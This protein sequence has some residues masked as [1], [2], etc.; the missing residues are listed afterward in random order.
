MSIFHQGTNHWKGLIVNERIRAEKGEI[1]F[2]WSANYFSKLPGKLFR[3]FKGS[4]FQVFNRVEL[5]RGYI[6]GRPF[7]LLSQ[8]PGLPLQQL[9][10]CLWKEERLQA[11]KRQIHQHQY[12]WETWT[13]FCIFN[14]A[15]FIVWQCDASP[16]NGE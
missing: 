3:E 9:R 12:T 13:K 10:M 7:L 4:Y 1:K 6:K 8:A 11:L 16:G 14:K 15:T 5:L 2:P